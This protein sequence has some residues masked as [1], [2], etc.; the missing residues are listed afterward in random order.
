[1]L[2]DEAEHDHSKTSAER[3]GLDPIVKK[4]IEALR[5]EPGIDQ[6]N[7]I[8]KLQQLSN[9]LASK[10]LNINGEIGSRICLNDFIK[11]YEENKALPDD[12][13]KV[14]VVNCTVKADPSGYPNFIFNIYIYNLLN[15]TITP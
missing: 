1:M 9:Y 15:I 2:R 10:R 8:P 5:N 3:P 4:Y 6:P 12:M 7:L 13:N 11:L 14:F